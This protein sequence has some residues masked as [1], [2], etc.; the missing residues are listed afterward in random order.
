M[1]TSLDGLLAAIDPSRTFDETA[2]RM[3]HAVNTFPAS[4]ACIQDWS[5]FARLMTAFFRHAE[6]QLLRIQPTYAGDP[7]MDWG[8]CRPVLCGVYGRNGEKTAFEMA[9]TG[10]EGGLYAVLRAVAEQMAEEYAL[11]EVR[12][13][14]GHYWQGLSV[15]EKMA[16]MEEYLKKWGHLLP[17]ELTEGSAARVKMDFP[18]VLELHVKLLRNTR[19]VGR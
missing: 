18:H 6:N 4:E 16:A 19:R 14:V 9:R 10:N 8:R 2:R 11:T 3:D 17:S 15:D 12:A 13:R 7:A 5:V 1:A